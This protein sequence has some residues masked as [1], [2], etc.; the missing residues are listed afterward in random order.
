MAGNVVARRLLSAKK[1]LINRK[2]GFSE[3]RH[4]LKPQN[5]SRQFGGT[6]NVNRTT[7]I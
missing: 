2:S 7:T 3:V 5:V 6:E 4:F 1:K